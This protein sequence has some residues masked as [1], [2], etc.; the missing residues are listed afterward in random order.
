MNRRPS[1]PSRLSGPSGRA[2]SASAKTRSDAWG[3]DLPEETRRQIYA[4][5]KP[6]TDEE[7]EG[8]RAWLRDFRRDVLPWLSLQGYVAPSQSAWYRFIKRMRVAEA[9]E[10]RISVEAAKEIAEGVRHVRV[11]AKLVAD[12]LTSR[13][14]DAATDQRP[15]SQQSAAILAAAAAKFHSS[16]IAEE[17]LKLDAARQRTADEQLRLAR[18]K[19]EAAEKRLAAVQ[20][21]VKSAKA[22]GG[23][24]SEETLRKIEEAAGLL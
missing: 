23:G 19:F 5:T 11:D 2:P 21:A 3:E 17:K 4:Y 16:A 20:E 24:L 1:R 15:E 12:Y 6:P 7:R 13:A 18:E 8:G 22:T 10:R 14:L 9:E